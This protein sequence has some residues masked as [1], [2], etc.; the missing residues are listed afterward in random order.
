MEKETGNGIAGK[1]LHQAC[2]RPGMNPSMQRQM[3]IRE[4]AEQIPHLTQTAM[5]GKRIAIRPRNMSVEHILMVCI[6]L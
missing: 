6:V 5:G 3:L 1:N 4:S 2:K